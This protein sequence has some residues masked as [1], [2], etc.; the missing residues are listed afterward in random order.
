MATE[1]K[2][3]TQTGQQ[4]GAAAPL[5]TRQE[6]EPGLGE[7]LTVRKQAIADVIPGKIFTADRIITLVKL[8]AN[9]NRDIAACNPASVLLAVLDLARVGLEPGGALQRAALVPYKGECTAQIMFQGM[10]ELMLRSGLVL[11]VQAHVVYEGD[12][13]RFRLGDRPEIYHVP[14]VESVDR[15]ALPWTHVYCVINLK[16]GGTIRDVMGH[17]A[18]MR[19]KA[20]SRSGANGKGPWSTDEAEMARKTVLKRA[21]KVAPKSDE[22]AEAI[23]MD[24]RD[25]SVGGHQEQEQEKPK[26]GGA[27]L[28]EL[29]SAQ[30]STSIGTA[31]P[32]PDAEE[33]ARIL[34][35]EKADAEKHKEAGGK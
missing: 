11:D 9:R 4:P 6:K 19:I 7:Y 15:E 20:R 2:Q 26:R 28:R 13:F 14:D 12:E 10:V 25:Y 17:G 31:P 22:L 30:A 1:T 27:K 21:A 16:G 23:E 24:N 3:Q 29:V 34:A 35:S 5:V 33:K 32:D 18:V 8:A